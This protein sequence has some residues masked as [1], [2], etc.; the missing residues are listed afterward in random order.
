MGKFLLGVLT[1]FALT[2][3]VFVLIVVA[4]LRFREKPA[5]VADGSTLVLRIEGDERHLSCIFRQQPLEICNRDIT[6][7][8]AIWAG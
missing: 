2:F 4:A 7:E 5:A 1:G 8:Q 6:L 3:L